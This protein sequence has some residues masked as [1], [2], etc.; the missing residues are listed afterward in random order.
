MSDKLDIVDIHTHLWPE[1]WG[2]KGARRVSSGLS[3][4]ILS[5]ITDPRALLDEFAASGVS[6][7]VLSTTIESLFGVEGPVD[8]AVI[9]EVNDWL[10]ALSKANPDRF[11]ALATV[12]PFSGDSADEE[13]ERALGELGLAGLVIDS[14]RGG[15][16]I[17]DQSVRPTLAVAAHYKVPVFVHPIN[18]P[19][20]GILV[21]GA[22]KL[23]NP[24]SILKEGSKPSFGSA[25]D[26]W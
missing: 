3:E 4:D 18:A 25:W 5:R 17:G 20:A 22:G 12:D 21:P 13:A 26:V 10:A 14:S 8:Y 24:E 1:D 11:A 16:F 7:A 15:R 6:L 23:G 2:L 19:Q 9:R